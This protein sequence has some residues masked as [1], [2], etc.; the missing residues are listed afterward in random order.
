MCFVVF[1]NKIMNQFNDQWFIQYHNYF[2][3]ANS[4]LVV[5]NRV[6]FQSPWFLFYLFVD[7]MLKK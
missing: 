1:T 6:R 2:Q 7:L 4:Y 3:F 5:N